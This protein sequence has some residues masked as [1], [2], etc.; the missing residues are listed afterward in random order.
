MNRRRRNYSRNLDKLVNS[1]PEIS[2]LKI[3]PVLAFLDAE[4]T[5]E[6]PLDRET[7]LLLLDQ[8]GDCPL[9]RE[10]REDILGIITICVAS[11]SSKERLVCLL[12]DAL[13]IVERPDMPVQSPEP[14]DPSTRCPF[15]DMDMLR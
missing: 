9:T 3:E 15:H 7:F 2:S 1:L 14:S 13:R 8:A 6:H 4:G 10:N 11:G 12:R 5:S